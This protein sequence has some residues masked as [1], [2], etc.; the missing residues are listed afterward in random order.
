MPTIC[1]FLTI[2]TAEPRSPSMASTLVPRVRSSDSETWGEEEE[3]EEKTKRSGKRRR[4]RKRINGKEKGV[5]V[6]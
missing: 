1:S 5:F 4:E 3:G 2:S 6:V